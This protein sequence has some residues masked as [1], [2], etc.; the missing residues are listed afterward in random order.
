M[1]MAQDTLGCL[2]T[3]H[4]SVSGCPCPWHLGTHPHGICVSEGAISM[5]S[6]HLWVPIP[7]VSGRLSVSIPTVS[8]YLWMSIPMTLGTSG[9]SQYY[10]LVMEQPLLPP[11]PSPAQEHTGASCRWFICPV[12]GQGVDDKDAVTLSCLSWSGREKLLRQE[13]S[14]P[15]P[16]TLAPHH[17]STVASQHLKSL[18]HQCPA[19]QQPRAL[20]PH[21]L[22]TPALQCPSIP[23]SWYSYTMASW[24]P[25]LLIPQF[26]G[27]PVP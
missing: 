20:V 23:E 18:A 6:G 1:P 8:E 11:D 27:T 7:V 4:L 17:L 16:N 24:H 22:G 3:C 21:W 12:P 19:P 25:S 2:A 9:C 26:S 5:A 13:D 14:T 10:P 15:T